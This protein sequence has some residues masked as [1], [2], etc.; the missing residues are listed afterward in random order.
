MV[1]NY[2][3][4][5]NHFTSL[6]VDGKHAALLKDIDE[7][8]QDVAKFNNE[9]LAE[10]TKALFADEEFIRY[11]TEGVSSMPYACC[12]VLIP[13]CAADYQAKQA[14]EEFRAPH[15]VGPHCHALLCCKLAPLL[16]VS[17]ADLCA[18]ENQMLTPKMSL[19]R[20]NIRKAYESMLGELFDE[21]TSFGHR[22]EH[23]S[24]L[25]NDF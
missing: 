16:L 9:S 15:E 3:E 5:K 1:P 12:L 22:I 17:P 8:I 7:C 19:R 6:N 21:K 25:V 24:P 11:V 2:L 23:A 18:Q 20:N 10:H 13:S 14:A 4:L